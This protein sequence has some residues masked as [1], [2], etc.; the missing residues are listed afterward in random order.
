MPS[1]RPRKNAPGGVNHPR[2]TRTNAATLE[3]VRKQAEARG[4]ELGRQDLAVE[5]NGFYCGSDEGELLLLA[6]WMD[7]VVCGLRIGGRSG[8]ESVGDEARDFALV[9]ERM[10]KLLAKITE[11]AN[12]PAF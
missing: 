11:E 12:R 9:S 6:K 8:Q 3:N 2:T 1:N 7:G 10:A 4:R 5:L